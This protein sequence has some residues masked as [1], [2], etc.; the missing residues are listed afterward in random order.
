MNA[1]FAA[2]LLLFAAVVHG[3]H[4]PPYSRQLTGEHACIDLLEP[5]CDC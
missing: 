1:F 3:A 2:A 5:L 4:L